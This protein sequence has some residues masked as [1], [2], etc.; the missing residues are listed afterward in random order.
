M[1]RKAKMYLDL[2]SNADKVQVGYRTIFTQRKR[3]QLRGSAPYKEKIPA[4]SWR[5]P[6]RTGMLRFM[7]Q[8]FDS[9]IFV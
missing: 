7:W 3:Q 5:V 6:R 2:N 4:P 9:T 8:G 1:Y